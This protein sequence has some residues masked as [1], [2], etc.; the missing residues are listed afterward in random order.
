MIDQE[1]YDLTQT[2]DE[3]QAILNNAEG[4]PTPQQL[5]EAFALKADKS[6]TYTKTEVDTKEAALSDRETFIERGLGKYDN[7]RSVTLQQV[8][9]GRLSLY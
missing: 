9:L 7:T 2:G 3:V 1:V 6:T 8:I 4:M 5:S